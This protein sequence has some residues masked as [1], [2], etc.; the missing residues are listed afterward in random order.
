MIIFESSHTV[1]NLKTNNAMIKRPK[2]VISLEGGKN[3][4]KSS[5]LRKV[6]ERLGLLGSCSRRKD[7]T[8]KLSWA[9]D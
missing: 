2:Y 5:T 4:G 1:N 7:F 3:C 6:A 8:G 9:V